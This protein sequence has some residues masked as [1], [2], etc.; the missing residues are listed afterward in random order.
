MPDGRKIPYWIEIG[1]QDD[2]LRKQMSQWNWEEIIGL[3]GFGEHFKKA[4]GEAGQTIERELNNT[5]I[6]WDKALQSDVFK[7]AVGDIVK[8]ANKQLRA[9]NLGSDEVQKVTEFI[10]EMGAAMKEVG[11]SIDT[12]GFARSMAAFASSIEPILGQVDKLKTVFAELFNKIDQKRNMQPIVST[13]ELTDST[14]QIQK[15]EKEILELNTL[16]GRVS[17]KEVDIKF[18][19]NLK[20]QFNNLKVNIVSIEDEIKTLEDRLKNTN[21]TNDQ[22]NT[23][24]YQLANERLSLAAH[25]RKMERVNEEYLKQNKGK[26]SLFTNTITTD[27]KKAIDIATEYTNSVVKQLQKVKEVANSSE[28]AINVEIVIPS[29]DAIR[30]QLNETIKK[31]NKPGSLNK[32]IVELDTATDLSN[33]DLL[34]T[35]KANQDIKINEEEF[36][37]NIKRLQELHREKKALEKEQD[38]NYGGVFAPTRDSRIKEI[39]KE[40][41]LLI[42]AQQGLKQVQGTYGEH[43]IASILKAFNSIDS[44]VSQRT[45]AWREK[46]VKAFQ[47]DKGEI[48]V[49]LT[50]EYSAEMIFNEVQ[51]FFQANE[52]ELHLNKE[53]FIQEIKQAVGEGGLSINGL[54]G[55]TVAFDEKTMAMAIATGLQAFFTGDFKAVTGEKKTVKGVQEPKK[56]HTY[57]DPSNPFNRDVAKSLGEVL[58]AGTQKGG[59]KIKDFFSMKGIDVEKAANS[60]AAELLDMLGQLTDRFGETIEDQFRQLMSDIGKNGTGAKVGNFLGD[61][62]E[63]LYTNRISQTTVDD[64]IKKSEQAKLWD[65]YAKRSVLQSGLGSLIGLTGKHRDITKMKLPTVEDINE[66]IDVAKQYANKDGLESVDKQIEE[67]RL[68]I[69]EAEKVGKTKELSSLTT[70]LARLQ[71]RQKEMKTTFDFYSPIISTLETIK[72]AR[73]IITDASND[74]Q[75]REFV[76]SVKK[77]QSDIGGFLD[78]LTEA[79]NGFHWGLEID[80]KKGIEEVSSSGKASR[81]FKNILGRDNS[82]VKTAHL[83]SGPVDKKYLDPIPDRT[84]IRNVDTTIPE[85]KLKENTDKRWEAE[86]TAAIEASKRATES[87]KLVAETE[88]RLTEGAKAEEAIKTQIAK[89]SAQRT[90]DQ[91]ALTANRKELESLTNKREATRAKNRLTTLDAQLE[92]VNKEKLIADKQ[93]EKYKDTDYSARDKREKELNAEIRKLQKWKKDP[94]LYRNDIDI[95]YD[96]VIEDARKKAEQAEI[97]EAQAWSGLPKRQ[98]DLD[99]YILS[100]EE[101]AKDAR[102]RGDEKLAQVYEKDVEDLRRVRDNLPNEM[103]AITEATE[104]AWAEYDALM[105]KIYGGVEGSQADYIKESQAMIEGLIQSK[106]IE[107]SN[108]MPNLKKEAQ[109]NQAKAN[110]QI[111]KLTAK[112]DTL[113]SS[114]EYQTSQSMDTLK[115]E[116]ERLKSNIEDA[117]NQL[118]QLQTA[119]KNLTPEKTTEELLNAESRNVDDIVTE[120]GNLESRLQAAKEDVSNIESYVDGVI[121]DKNY[122]KPNG[123]IKYTNKDKK[124]V[125]KYVEASNRTS[126]I[127]RL[128]SEDETPRLDG[129]AN[130][131][132]K[133][134]GLITN[135]KQNQ[136]TLGYVDRIQ[137]LFT[138]M[139]GEYRDPN[140]IYQDIEKIL[141]EIYL[142]NEE[143]QQKAEQDGATSTEK[144]KAQWSEKLTYQMNEFRDAYKANAPVEGAGS[145]DIF[146]DFWGDTINA[147]KGDLNQQIKDLQVVSN[148]SAKIVTALQPEV[149]AA[150]QN[151][152]EKYINSVQKWFKQIKAKQKTISKGEIEGADMAAKNAAGLAAKEIS[153]LFPLIT[154]A[155]SE[156]KERFKEDLVLTE[157]DSKLLSNKTNYRSFLS[158]KTSDIE[159]KIS[160]TK[161][162]VLSSERATLL[163]TRRGELLR[164]IKTAVSDKKDTKELE[165]ALKAVNDELS[166]YE[167]YSSI[168]SKDAVSSVFFQDTEFANQ[169]STKLEEII[170]KENELDLAQTKGAPQADIKSKYEAINKAHIESED[171]LRNKLQEK[172]KALL[173]DIKINNAEGKSVT[174]L[175]KQLD[176]VNQELVQLEINHSKRAQT[177]ISG[178]LYKASTMSVASYTTALKE[179]IIAKQTLNKLEAQGLDT[180]DAAK[181]Y[182]RANSSIREAIN[183]AINARVNGPANADP[184]TQALDYLDNTEE[185]YRNALAKKRDA[186]RRKRQTEAEL[187]ALR[188]D[189]RYSTSY[190]YKNHYNSIKREVTDDYVHSDKYRNER[191]VGLQTA[192]T[193]ME[194]YLLEALRPAAENAMKAAEYGIDVDGATQEGGVEKLLEQNV[195]KVMYS[196]MQSLGKKGAKIDPKQFTEAIALGGQGGWSGLTTLFE[197]EFSTTQEYKNITAPL[198]EAR[199]VSFESKL[200]ELDTQLQTIET[201]RRHAVEKIMSATEKDYEPLDKIMQQK[202][203][204]F[205]KIEAGFKRILSDI[206]KNSN[207]R[208]VKRQLMEVTKRYGANKYEREEISKAIEDNLLNRRYDKINTKGVMASVS[209]DAVRE[210]SRSLLQSQQET[211]ARRK[212]NDITRRQ[213]GLTEKYNTGK[214]RAD[215]DT[216]LSFKN[217]IDTAMAQYVKDKLNPEKNKNLAEVFTGDFA[218][219][220]GLS[221]DIMNTFKTLMEEFVFNIVG[222]HSQSLQ[223]KDGLLPGADLSEGNK[224]RFVTD[225]AGNI[226]IQKTIEKRLEAQRNIAEEDLKKAEKEIADAER[227]RKDAM[228]KG[229]LSRADAIDAETKKELAEFQA[230]ITAEKVRQKELTAEINRL[231]KEGASTEELGAIKGQLDQ[232]NANISKFEKFANNRDLLIEMNRKAAEDEKKLH[233]YTLDEQKLFY[234]A[235]RA[236]AEERLGS[237]DERVRKK[238]EEDI[239]RFDDILGRIVAKIEANAAKEREKNDPMNILASRFADAIRKSLG[240]NN[241]LNVDATGLAT[242][243]TLSQIY[244]MLVGIVQA[245]GGKVIRDPEKDAMLAELRALEAKKTASTR[246]NSGGSNKRK[247]PT[248]KYADDFNFTDALKKQADEVGKHNKGTKEYILE[249]AKLYKLLWDYKASSPELSKL[250]NKDLYN[251]AEIKSLGLDPKLSSAKKRTTEY[252]NLGGTEDIEALAQE[253]VNKFKIKIA[254]NIDKTK[255]T[256]PVVEVKPKVAK[257]DAKDVANK[258][259]KAIPLYD[260]KTETFTSLQKKA[261]ALKSELDTMYDEGKKDTV[262]FIQKQTELGR[263]MSLMR[264]KYSEKHPEVYGVKGDKESQKVANETWQKYLTTGTRGRSQTF[265]N[266]DGVQLTSVSKAN[267]T[268]MVKALLGEEKPKLESKEKKEDIK[269]KDFED[270]KNRVQSL[271]K[272]IG[273][274]EGNVEAQRKSQEQLIDVLRAWVKVDPNKINGVVTKKHTM[275]N[276]KEWETY[277]TN[278][279]LGILKSVDTKKTPLT[280]KQLN[281]IYSETTDKD[282][283]NAEKEANSKER[284][285]SAAQAE[286]AATVQVTEEKTK[287]KDIESSYTT[288]DARRERE[289]KQKLGGYTGPQVDFSETDIGL[290]QEETLKAILNSVT[291]IQTEG[292]KKGGSSAKNKKTTSA[293]EA[294]LIKRRALS[295]HEA[296]LG[297]GATDSSKIIA[298]ND[299]VTQLDAAIKEVQA[300]TKAKQGTGEA[301]KNVKTLAQR[302]SA[303]SFNIMK[304]ASIWDYTVKEADKVG[305]IDP[306]AQQSVREQMEALAQKNLNGKQYKFLNFDGT[307]LSYQLIDVK[308]NVEKL[309]MEWSELN[310]QVAITSDKSVAK[311]EPLSGRLG[312]ANEKFENASQMG[313]LDKSGKEF[314]EYDSKL[315]ILNDEMTKIAEKEIITDE[316]YARI[317][318]LKNDA[319]RASDEVTKKIA[320]NKKL[321]TGTSEMNAAKKQFNRLDDSG[322]LDQADLKMV[323]EYKAKY[324]DI[325]RIHNQWKSKDNGKGLL[326]EEAQKQ[327]RKASLEAQNIGKE[328]EKAVGHSQKL[329]QAVANSGMYN[330]QKIGD[331]S[332]VIDG[333]DIYDQMVTKLKELGAE[334]IKVDRIR[335]TATGT[336]RHSNRTVS[337][338]T[339]EYDKLT[340]SLARYQKQERE[341]L[342]G[343]P[344]FLNG[345][346]KKFT[347]IMQYM[348]MSFSIY[349]L[350]AQVRQ[351]VQYVKE[352]D[353]ALTELRKVTNET[354]ETYDKFLEEAAKTGA[355]L[356]ATISAVTEATATFAK[357]GY[358][359]EMASEM[360]KSAIVYKNVGD[361]IESTEDAANSIISTMKGFRMEASE[362]MAIVDRFNEVGNR[363]AIT[364]QG[365]GEALKLSASALSEGGNSLDESIG[366]ITAANEVVNDPSSVGTALKT[367]TLR[368]RGSKTELEE[369]G[370]DISDMATTTSSLQAKLLALTGGKVDI[371]LD[372]TTF[373]NSTQILREMAE[374][375][376][377]MDDISRASA[378][379]LMGGKR[380]ANVLSALIQNFDTVEKVIETSANSAGSALEENERYLDSIQGKLDQFTNSLQSAWSDLLDSDLIKYIV[381]AGTELLKFA[382]N[383][384][385]VKTL[386]TGIGAFL[387]QKNFKGDLWGGLFNPQT[388]DQSRE[389]LAN[390]KNEI[391]TLQGKKQTPLR[392]AKIKHKQ[393]QADSLGASI[394]EYDNLSKKSTELTNKLSGLQEKR[395]SLASDLADS[396]AHEDFLGKRMAAGYEDA[397]KG[398]DKVH[399]KNINLKNQIQ[400]IDQEIINTEGAIKNN[401]EAIKQA[402]HQVRNIGTTGLSASKKLKDGFNKAKVSIKQFG[403]SILTMYAITTAFEL[404]YK[405]GEAITDFIDGLDETAEEAQDKFNELNNELEATKS[406]LNNLESELKSTNDRIEELLEKPSLTLVEQE[407]LSKLQ[408][409]NRELERQIKFN[410][411]LKKSQQ[412]SV[413]DA[414]FVASARYQTG[415]SFYSEKTKTEREEEAKSTGETIGSTAGMIIGGVIGTYLG[416]NTL[417][418]AGAGSAIGSFVGGLFGTSSAGTAYDAELTVGDAVEQM[419]LIRASL[420]ADIRR[421]EEAIENNSGKITKEQK[422]NLQDAEKALSDF[423]SNMGTSMNQLQQY[424]NAIDYSS[425]VDPKDQQKYRDALDDFLKYNIEYGITGATTNA[426][427]TMLSEDLIT[428]DLQK[429]KDILS[430]ALESDDSIDFSYLES[431]LFDA[432]TQ[433]SIDATRERL[434]GV[435]LTITDLISYLRAEKVAAEEAME[436][437][438]YDVVKEVNKYADSIDSLTQ[439]FDEFVESGIVAGE[440]L[441]KLNEV[442]GD[443]EGWQKYID[444]MSGGVASTQEAIEATN[445]L[446]EGLL[447][448]RMDNPFDFGDYKGV[449]EN[450]QK[451]F[452]KNT[453]AYKA[454]LTEIQQLNALGVDNAKE[455]VDAMQQ[456]GLVQ[457]AVNNIKEVQRIEALGDKATQE[458]KDKLEKLKKDNAQEYA[459][460]IYEE[461]GIRIKNTEL[462]E[463]QLKLSQTQDKLKIYDEYQKN[464]FGVSET[465]LDDYNASINKTKDLK[466]EIEDL[467]KQKDNYGI[468]EA[469]EDA[470]FWEAFTDGM[471]YSGKWGQTQLDRKHAELDGY[472]KGANDNLQ[473]QVEE[474]KRL[475]NELTKI[476]RDE[477]LDKL[478]LTEDIL[479]SFNPTDVSDNS[480]FNQV[481][482]AVRVYLYGEDGKGGK[483]AE[484]KATEEEIKKELGTAFDT[485]GLEVTL[486]LIDKNKLV[487][488]IQSVF[489]TLKNS[490]KEFNENGYLSVDTAQ[491]LLDPTVMDPKYLTLLKDENGQLQLNEK[492]L[493]DVAIARLTDLKLKQQ[494][495]ILKEAEALS[496]QGSV[497]ALREQTEAIY[498]EANA[499]DILIQQRLKGIETKLQERQANGEL[500]GLNVDTYMNNIKN[501]LQAVDHITT[502][503]INNIQNSLSSAGNTAKQEAEDAFKKAM[504]YWENRIGANQSLYE[505]LQN[506]IDLLEK[507]GQIAGESYYQA[508]IDVEEEHLQHLKDQRDEATEFLKGEKRGTERWWEIANTLNDIEG[509][510]DSVTLSIQDLSDA[511]AQVHWDVFDQA[512][513]RMDDLTAQLSNVREIL[514]ADEDSF[515][516]DEGEWSDTGIAVLATHIQ[517]IAVAEST[518]A[519][520]EKEL[521]NLKMSDFDSEN[522]YYDKLTELTEKQQDYTMAISDSEQAVVDMY[523]SNIDAVEEYF[524]KL[525]ENYNDYIDSVKEA[526]D[527]ERDLYEFKKNIQ[528]QSKDIAEI[529][530]RIASLSGSTNASDV[531]ERRKLEA[532]LYESR[533]S[534]NDTYY[535][536]AK[537]SQQDALDAEA[538]A[539]EETLTKMVEGMRLGLEEATTNMQTF[540]DR[541]TIA[542]SMNA[543]DVLKKYQSTEL[544]LSPALTNPWEAAK[545]AVGEYGGDANNLMD[546]WAKDGYFAK[547][548]SEAGTNLKSPFNAGKTAADE[549]GKSVGSAM[550]NVYTNIQSNVQKSVT[551]LD[552]IKQ[553]YKE[554][555]D[556]V[557]RPP[558]G[559][560]INNG[561]GGWNEILV[562]TT[563]VYQLQQ[564]IKA[565]FSAQGDKLNING[566]YDAATKS[567]VARIQEK[568]GITPSGLYDEKT[569]QAMQAW[570]NEQNVGSWF[571]R[572][573]FGIPDAMYAKGTTGTTRDQWAITDEPKFGDELV[574]VPGKDG[575]LSF[576]R[577]GTGVVPADMTQK[578]FELAQIPTSDLMNKNLTAIV[579]NITK[580]D[581]KNEFNFESLVHV[582]TV[583]SDTLPKL[584]KMVDKKIDDFSKALNYSIKRFAR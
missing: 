468:D 566:I 195:Q 526:L 419:S 262:E 191:E 89:L 105:D 139:H 75:K 248:S 395:N 187:E 294:E 178:D 290:A 13:A 531:A 281:K 151:L 114:K 92:A 417:I 300:K 516:T 60:S 172:Q 466:Q 317:E 354:K 297:L 567:A 65:D 495:A 510:I 536:H 522:E 15:F 311:L 539:Y 182:Q 494:D 398:L 362:S 508:Q 104:R 401:T 167:K 32:V 93:A 109:T 361:N 1:I 579:P 347:S 280:G 16:L 331:I 459:E 238:A 355:K 430:T 208:D 551:E 265:E 241:G 575:N 557:S 133:E 55:G 570:L 137:S 358:S 553:K 209:Q 507:K 289:L 78:R 220:L 246:E 511:M 201:E 242:E 450:G 64:S 155:I 171:M 404:I 48:K 372:E 327:L 502:S 308:G 572:V 91:E 541:V 365:I 82:K 127:D 119:K 143:N 555:N 544:Y 194:K 14:K 578:L 474:R 523:E 68:K 146:N 111:A 453:A 542:V 583:D 563:E 81:L 369:M 487:D 530:R 179:A 117:K 145:E 33:K 326:S 366:L 142:T 328:L 274:Q 533:E 569:K 298:Y 313:Y 373:K 255:Q 97:V 103:K 310:N 113:I 212:A 432:E 506:D 524:D 478:G 560:G 456:K 337:D 377:D 318:Q 321:Y 371:M 556:E 189:D 312:R 295:N 464:H 203:P 475:W 503:A 120:I 11:T 107:K 392:K 314:T 24:S 389:R 320:Q 153:E 247:T 499:Y 214:W 387:I 149:D 173:E 350:V 367:L 99:R 216:E 229:G 552:K 200:A 4:A 479:K 315:K 405:A 235:K 57:F 45:G 213:D 414:A 135:I 325:D 228:E 266:L 168:L 562:P 193:E 378:L 199:K 136:E 509:E 388:V 17:K 434:A 515:F 202:S 396:Q 390:L 351:G 375:W 128:L 339:V 159:D 445:N 490:V 527:A 197:Q 418:G 413:N 121:K 406:E 196:L 10:S 455:L 37:K 268:S 42:S 442:F 520:V 381:Q 100:S 345:F 481:Y 463:K 561:G 582:D 123:D 462:I 554:I 356:G 174:E 302:I 426:L 53:A 352:I 56:T 77:F 12:K 550:T 152:K 299:L 118:K 559:A 425:L 231:E 435:N 472:I 391:T 383:L 35:K 469:F 232:T 59:G 58:K 144:L 67:I 415:T 428:D 577:K 393:K 452:K 225:N 250:A 263:V 207:M 221:T 291:K 384:G 484:L 574:L 215:K 181:D 273:E 269:I 333:I 324:A 408:A 84:A 38:P 5:H 96:D 156:Y 218:K 402:E 458:E 175:T 95:L 272:V 62:R 237:D 2:K 66:Y 7:K 138:D 49:P 34:G 108:L 348:T 349:R 110:E 412:Q 3:K 449:D 521:K 471:G 245:M 222:K 165:K 438:T 87:E 447:V 359:M 260:A 465:I 227:K 244:E 440:T 21:L 573:G 140:L 23:L 517:D 488:D 329:G 409:T 568:L 98:K 301:M 548:S 198:D 282:A 535:D 148:D 243:A 342:T 6:N 63:L 154:K 74:G 31:L 443:V 25:Y 382:D 451:T 581:F 330:G 70:Q 368:L 525:I 112:R 41:E 177:S 122:K 18:N 467:Q 287:Q 420:T 316:D 277:L 461:Y 565:L 340:G 39:K 115:A 28:N 47:L 343:L 491:Q 492:T 496:A 431:G 233:T 79:L 360:A 403:A 336:V 20:Q 185:A 374:A 444:V 497:E 446:A 190:Q 88:K 335:Q 460:A 80:G 54:G 341:S 363:F 571:R 8:D 416:G 219:E 126:Y 132:E 376:E 498:G 421:A 407:E 296:I 210:Y 275:P 226:N 319:L 124:V 223:V 303:M 397:A 477:G 259:W 46:I 344:A 433:K 184:R 141:N 411:I 85:F 332:P 161:D 514:S 473:V 73:N 529:E 437:E 485:I 576:M 357:L 423:D 441:I 160:T 253:F 283:V 504:E 9:K 364:S 192:F 480:V 61:F 44:V 40:M 157:E 264:K 338:L 261:K 482:D 257:E 27:A 489:D 385:V 26:D 267:F 130:F 236:K 394:A 400:Q 323:E 252:K 90:A 158:K 532:E 370:E 513:E 254:E 19:K 538:T 546:V 22:K 176:L 76:N 279:E 125:D 102:G 379:E 94:E 116:N 83:Y 29:V 399:S 288:E 249:Q 131:S 150:H 180:T 304:E 454:Y 50:A 439:A 129:F 436:W 476:A 256:L 380:Q 30:Q 52:I 106:Q 386:I 169:Y 230:K 166:K 217:Q 558:S 101:S 549:F 470:P 234:E 271:V 353:L 134:L 534:L 188:T 306:S 36:Q 547:F 427:S 505:Q 240:G 258:A 86:N 183:N 545:K 424:L 322:I 164:D 307:K 284:V 422:Q 410:E 204:K 239:S 584:E 293:D 540:L 429:V 493:Y 543:E 483:M 69:A 147:I 448:D 224:N 486:D 501:Q 43:T 457:A 564:M 163:K 211:Y 170:S 270:F 537:Q 162:S 206:N 286:A 51:N 71:A 580:N 251:R 519:D 309:T 186:E 292:I 205:E 276:A 528:K 512:H 334:H 285:A 305:T 518:L 500:D 72:E 278:P 346:K